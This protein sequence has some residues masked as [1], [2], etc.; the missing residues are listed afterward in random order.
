MIKDI[1]KV[2]TSRIFRYMNSRLK[3]WAFREF[4][5][6]E[7]RDKSVNQKLI[8][9]I[10]SDVDYITC[11]IGSSSFYFN[12]LRYSEK[13]R[14]ETLSAAEKSGI[15]PDK[16]DNLNSYMIHAIKYRKIL[17][18]ISELDMT[19]A[20]A[21]EI[22]H[23]FEDY[24]GGLTEKVQSSRSLHKLSRAKKLQRATS[25]IMSLFGQDF[26]SVMLPYIMG[27]PMLY[28]EFMASKIGLD[29]LRK[30]GCNDKQI[31]MAKRDLRAAWTTYFS[32][33]TDNALFGTSWGAP[34]IKHVGK[35]LK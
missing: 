35:L 11:D 19:S 32:G 21:H 2:L 14:L 34:M 4:Q 25:F 1:V 24:N 5:R 18:C 33:V 12:P 3:V 28:T 20:L 23:L 22:G 9:L 30:V 29:L 17:I 7:F 26:L 8:D 27:S 6:G 10:P 15:N 16:L 31:E 13:D